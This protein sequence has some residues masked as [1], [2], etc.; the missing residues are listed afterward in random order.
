MS[1]EE[2]EETTVRGLLGTAFDAA[3]PPLRD[4]ASGSIARGDATR[5]RNRL[6][7]A[8]GAALS[9]V[10]V[11]GTF[12]A[13]TGATPVKPGHPAPAQQVTSAATSASPTGTLAFGPTLNNIDKQLDIRNRLAAL[14]QPLLPAAITAG[15][16]PV[17]AMPQPDQS[18][19]FLTGSTGTNQA[20]MWVGNAPAEDSRVREAV[21]S[22]GGNCYSKAVDGGTLH[23]EEHAYTSLD[24]VRGAGFPAD[25][26]K[27][28]TSKTITG[29]ALS[30]V[31]VP[32]DRSRYAISFTESTTTANP[33]YAD[34]EPSDYATGGEWPPQIVSSQHAFDSA[35]LLM[36][37]DDL[38][39]LVAKPG[40]DKVENLL[41]PRTA[42]SPQTQAQIKDIS[43][44]ILAA[45][46]PAMPAGVTAG[47]DLSSPQ[48]QLVVT[49]P[50]AKNVVT[51]QSGPQSAQQRQQAVGWCPPNVT[52]TK[53]TVPG[54]LLVVWNERPMDSKGTI[55][56]Q[57]P[58]SYEYWF[59]P[60]DTSK[61][62]VTMT[63]DLNATR[64]GAAP[65]S[66]PDP[67]HT[68]SV[69]DGP[70]VPVQVSADQFLAAAQSG[71]LTTA[72]SKTTPLIAT[73]M[74]Q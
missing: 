23:F 6:F 12:A 22:Q 57:T 29:R 30:M 61:P 2:H 1:I 59:L 5:H 20:A 73:L 51:W 9:V 65:R 70:Y 43:S 7:T 55:L 49:G 69:S 19:V 28:G 47:I 11:I 15:Q 36:S 16:V 50:T 45:A 24:L 21:C 74:G 27:A 54:G 32:N 35:G 13:V 64:T 26:L 66:I 17:D 62:E 42:V 38:A 31:F 3:E 14:V 25:V 67:G 44:Q 58:S 10:A 53:R 40:L 39:A 63:L 60:D 46:Q 34:H 8:G 4:L 71:Q 56:E 33:Q 68:Y 52:C 37:P 48:A 72:I 41:D 18:T